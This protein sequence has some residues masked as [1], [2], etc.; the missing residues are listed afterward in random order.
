LALEKNVLGFYLSG[1]PL[2][3]WRVDIESIATVNLGEFDE[4]L[5][6]TTV[7]AVGIVSAFRPK[8]DKKGKTM[9]FLT[10]E[11]FTGR[12]ECLVFEAAYRKFGSVI[13]PE[14][15]LVVIGKVRGSGDSFSLIADEIYTLEQAIPR[16][17]KSIVI[18]LSANTTTQKQV[19]DGIRLLDEFC[20]TGE[21]PC[22][23]RVSD[24]NGRSWNLFAKD[25]RLRPSL[26]LLNRMRE[27]FGRTAVRIVLDQ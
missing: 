3:S 10:L 5:D 17:T 27:I 1:H 7:R 6:G 18:T 23:I 2:E 20:R 14:A 11:D 26:D 12:A 13:S 16:L 9:A 22:F 24:G 8:I 4:S 25:H 15:A 19:E 21:C